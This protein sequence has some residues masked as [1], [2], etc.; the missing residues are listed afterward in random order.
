MVGPLRRSLLWES[1]IEKTVSEEGLPVVELKGRFVSPNWMAGF[2]IGYVFVPDPGRWVAAVH[3]DGSDWFPGGVA[4]VERPGILMAGQASEAEIDGLVR[5][6][7]VQALVKDLKR[8]GK[9]SWGLSDFETGVFWDMS[10][11]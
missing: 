8:L 9:S 10:L 4:F 2:E 5:A 6:R 7:T 3:E 11:S 1:R